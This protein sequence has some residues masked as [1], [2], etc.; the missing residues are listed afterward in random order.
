MTDS[1]LDKIAKHVA[2]VFGRQPEEVVI[3]FPGRTFVRITPEV[4]ATTSKA[5]SPEVAKRYETWT[6]RIVPYLTKVGIPLNRGQIAAGLN[7][8]GRLRT[9]SWFG[10]TIRMLIQTG[11]LQENDRKF[12]SVRKADVVPE[13]IPEVIKK[14]KET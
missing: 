8:K 1:P 10:R 5:I 4:V 14:R 9:K 2:E 6:N 11:T 13:K 12:I 3:R 7:L